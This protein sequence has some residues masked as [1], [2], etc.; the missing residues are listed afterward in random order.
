MYQQYMNQIQSTL[1]Y[2]SSDEL[3]ELLNNDDELEKRVDEAVRI[4]F[5]LDD[6]VFHLFASLF[7]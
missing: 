5:L 3:K 6:S 4:E 2:L 7:S 1:S